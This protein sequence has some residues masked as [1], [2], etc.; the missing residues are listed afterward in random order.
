MIMFIDTQL[1]F[2]I[3]KILV[4]TNTNVLHAALRPN[5]GYFILNTNPE[6][7]KC[8]MTQKTKAMLFVKSVTTEQTHLASWKAIQ[9]EKDAT[10]ISVNIA[11]LRHPSQKVSQSIECTE[12]VETKLGGTR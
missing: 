3:T 10:N 6:H 7:V 1:K 8:T 2:K 5:L 11:H 9:T 12:Y 4:V